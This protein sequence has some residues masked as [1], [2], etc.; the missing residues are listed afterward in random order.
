[1]AALAVVTECCVCAVVVKETCYMRRHKEE[2]RERRE[3]RR[4]RCNLFYDPISPRPEARRVVVLEKKQLLLTAPKSL[5][6][7]LLSLS[8]CVMYLFD[9]IVHQQPPPYTVHKKKKKRKI[10]LPLDDENSSSS[11]PPE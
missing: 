6:F 4:R 1:M 3:W 5:C 11:I 7:C 8:L 9:E 10:P 2:G